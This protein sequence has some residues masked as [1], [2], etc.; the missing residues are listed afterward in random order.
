M[1]ELKHCLESAGF[2]EVRTVLTSGNVVF[3]ARSGRSEALLARRIEAALTKNLDRGFGTFVRSIVELKCIL[4]AD[5][6]QEFRL[7]PGMKRVVTFLREEAQSDLELPIKNE[8]AAILKVDGATVFS[9][10]KPS[11]KGPVFMALI[12]KTF[13]KDVTTRTWDTIRQVV[14]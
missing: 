7:K 1:P 12:E 13:G 11:P 6:F 10:Y 8:G 4:D 2:T 5:P 3:S 9:A 14:R